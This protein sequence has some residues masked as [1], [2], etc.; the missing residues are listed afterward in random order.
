MTKIAPV[1]AVV[2]QATRAMGS[3]LI[4]ESRMASEI[5]SQSLS[6]CP[7][8]T[9]SEVKSLCAIKKCSSLVKTASAADGYDIV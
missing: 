6:G 7:S 9:D 2:S 1:L 5:W 8:V 3:R 4:M